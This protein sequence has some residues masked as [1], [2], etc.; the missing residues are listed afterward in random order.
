MSVLTILRFKD[1]GGVQDGGLKILVLENFK[2]MK[3]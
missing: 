1:P 2:K 3:K